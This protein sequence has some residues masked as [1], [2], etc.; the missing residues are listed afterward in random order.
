[1]RRDHA[2]SPKMETSAKNRAAAAVVSFSRKVWHR[3]QA[4]VSLG[5]MRLIFALSSETKKGR[6]ITT[7]VL[8]MFPCI[9]CSCFGLH[10]RSTCTAQL[11]RLPWGDVA[12]HFLTATPMLKFVKL[13]M[14]MRGDHGTC[15]SYFRDYYSSCYSTTKKYIFYFV[16]CGRQTSSAARLSTTYI[17]SRC[18][19]F[20]V[21]ENI[22]KWLIRIAPSRNNYLSNM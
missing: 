21:V 12:D 11:P 14:N 9:V 5:S 8:V 20:V 15:I 13:Q 17:C 19:Y 4:V 18:T 1:M 22:K 7:S 6:E 10:I 2:H 3:A 16:F